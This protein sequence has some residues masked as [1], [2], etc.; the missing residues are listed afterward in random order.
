[1]DHD[2]TVVRLRGGARGLPQPASFAAYAVEAQDG[3]EG[4][5]LELYRTALRLRRKLL[6]G[7]ALTWADSPPGVLHFARSDGW[8]CVTNLSGVP[9]ALPP[10]ELLLSSEPAAGERQLA[11]D[12][13]VWLGV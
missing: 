2:G 4:S 11:P 13:T 3:T 10:G 9:V 7:E 5:T 12:T 8:R 1:M 6:D